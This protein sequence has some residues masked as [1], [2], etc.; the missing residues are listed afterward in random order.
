MYETLLEYVNDRKAVDGDWDGNVPANYKT[1][2]APPKAL[3]RWINRQRTAHQKH[4]LKAEFADKLNSVGLKWSVHERRLVVPMSQ[5]QTPIKN[6]LTVAQP[7][8]AGYRSNPQGPIAAA[9][10]AARLAAAKASGALPDAVKSNVITATAT[11]KPNVTSIAATPVKIFVTK[12]SGTV[13]ATPVKPAAIIFVTKTSDT[14]AATPSPV[15]S[16]ATILAAHTSGIAAA[17]AANPVTTSANA[18]SSAL[19]KPAAPV[20]QDPNAVET[21]K[22]ISDAAATASDAVVTKTAANPATGTSPPA[23]A[24]HA[25]KIEEGT[26]PEMAV[27]ASNAVPATIT[28]P[29]DSPEADSEDLQSS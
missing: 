26:E 29:S 12:T 8:A 17:T 6:N 18:A 1:N 3:G 22:T 4:K 14:A 9:A 16:S 21:T 15:K 7:P 13:A 10:A 20:T 19:T 2:D 23:E 27:I 25:I 24:K 11:T 28:P 5:L